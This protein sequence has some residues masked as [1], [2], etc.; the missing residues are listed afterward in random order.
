MT[1]RLISAITLAAALI[2]LAGHIAVAI[3]AEIDEA[4]SLYWIDTPD[5]LPESMTA[6]PL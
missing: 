6:D 2:R 5:Y 1:A 3:S 4:V